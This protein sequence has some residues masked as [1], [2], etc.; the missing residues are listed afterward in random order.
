MRVLVLLLLAALSAPAFQS[1]ALSDIDSVVAAAMKELHVPGVAVGVIRDGKV[2]LAKGYGLRDSTRKQPVTA[3]TVFAV[4]SVTKSFTAASCAT[5][6]DEGKLEWDKPVRDY[7]PWFRL[8]DPIATEL[9]TARD[10]L[11]HRSGL[12][13]HDFIR[14]S[15]PLSREEFMRR[16]RYLEPSKTFRET[17]QYNNL[18]YVAAGFL[19]AERARMSWE[20]LIRKRLFEPLEMKNSTVA[21]TDT[22][23]LSD[24]ARPHLDEGGAVRETDFYD[25]QRFGIGPNGAVN[26]SVNDML[27]YLQMHLDGGKA[28]TRQVIS[29]AQMRELHRGVTAVGDGA[30]AL[31]WFDEDHRGH[32]MFTHG[33]GITGFTANAAFFPEKKIGI[34]VLNNLGSALPTIVTQSIAQRMLGI[35]LEDNLKRFLDQ[36][37][38]NRREQA[39]KREPAASNGKPSLPLAAYASKYSHPAFGTIEVQQNGDDLKL[40]FSAWTSALKHRNYDTF[41]IERLGGAPAQFQLDT[42]G[43]IETLL[44]PLE[45]AVKPFVFRRESPGTK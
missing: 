7:L 36:R 38:R 29:S 42:K 21:V 27:K 17:F 26:S 23:K 4:G 31:G 43:K 34:V 8:H 5:V 33:G 9:I 14:M 1:D 6:V 35:T 19:C 44:L 15:T 10:L 22:Q 28:G 11:T 18:M 16:L 37:D 2:V 30:Y 45:P 12:P 25:Y 13:R 32:R 40:V 3:D 41:S 20:D 39:A 24:F